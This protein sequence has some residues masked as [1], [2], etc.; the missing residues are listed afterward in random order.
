MNCPWNMGAGST[1]VV[2]RDCLLP[3]H[4]INSSSKKKQMKSSF[5]T[6]IFNGDLKNA[7]FTEL[8]SKRRPAICAAINC[9]SATGC[10]QQR[11]DRRICR[12][13]TEK[14]TASTRHTTE[15]SVE[16][17]KRIAH[18]LIIQYRIQRLRSKRDLGN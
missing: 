16:I 3:S 10:R 11:H 14:L 18:S 1:F 17:D 7:G 2:G 5:G 6:P 4:E 15:L 13:G 12:A 9:E 8:S